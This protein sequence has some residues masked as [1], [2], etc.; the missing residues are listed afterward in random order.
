MDDLLLGKQIHFNEFNF[1][2][3]GLCPD[4][5]SRQMKDICNDVADLKPT[6]SRGVAF[7]AFQVGLFHPVPSM[8]FL[9]FAVTG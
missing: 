3:G 7:G 4:K 9:S 2:P 6:S 8:M 5:S 1:P